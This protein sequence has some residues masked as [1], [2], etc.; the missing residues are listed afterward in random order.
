MCH[1][2]TLFGFGMVFAE[3]GRDKFPKVLTKRK[4]KDYG[5]N[6]WNRFGYNQFMCG[7]V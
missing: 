7:C 1:F 3:I 6:Y 5:K 4:D 2:V